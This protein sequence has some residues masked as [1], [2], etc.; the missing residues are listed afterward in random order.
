MLVFLQTA[1]FAQPQ[2]SLSLRYNALNYVTP[3]IADHEFFD[4][5]S[6]TD[7]YGLEVEYGCRIA[8]KTYLAF[9]L[10]VGKGRIAENSRGAG[11]DK[12]IANLD[13]LLHYNFLKHNV[14]LNPSFHF[15]IG[16]GWYPEIPDVDVNL[17]MGL[18]LD[19]RL[20]KRVHLTAQ[21]QYRFAG[22][23]RTGWQHA[24]GFT[25]Y[26]GPDKTADRDKDGVPDLT[27]RCPDVPGLE[28]LLGCPDRD[29]DGVTDMDDHCPD[30]A[31]SMAMM[32]CPDRDSDGIT[33]LEDSCP[34]VAGMA[35]MKGCPDTDSDGITDAEDKCP[36]EAG[37][38]SNMGCPIRDRDSD[39]VVDADDRC[40]DDKGPVSTK[41]CPDR[42]MDGVADK[43]DVCPDKKGDSMHY[44]CPDTDGDGVY[45]N[46]DRCVDKAGPASNRG[47][48]EI[49]KED[50]AKVELAVK[51]VQFESGKAVLLTKSYK[52]L[53]D[54]ATVLKNYPYYSLDL[55]GHTDSQGDD[56]MNH[57]LSHAR[58]K[59]CYD[60]LISK[61]IPASRLTSEGFGESKPIAD[62][63]TAAGRALNRRVEFDLIVK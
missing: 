61:G 29:S 8:P 40:P 9:P 63:K 22:G 58:A 41:G 13:L 3:R 50:R 10:K 47:C 56:Q 51:A 6:K 35:A 2:H 42:D 59:A 44:G 1:T 24:I 46:D 21:T 53:D 23:K 28:N 30:V 27:D 19:F 39:G 52:V 34:D 20:S 37:P 62:N 38:A 60:Y 25:Q 45:D 55:R 48:P 26:L 18:G 7:G 14:F 12:I 33:D 31:G 43:D 32:G 4:A 36:R 49:K 54:V 15:G 5:Y 11:S 17:P 57:D 16:A